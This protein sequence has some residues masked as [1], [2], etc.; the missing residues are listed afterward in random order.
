MYSNCQL[1]V[2]D[3]KP[4]EG[5]ILNPYLEINQGIVGY[6]PMW[7]GAGSQVFDLSGNGWTGTAVTSLVWTSGKFGSA[8]DFS[9][10]NRFKI[11][12]DF[13]T[14]EWSIVIWAKPSNLTASQY[15][16]D[17][18]Q[19]RTVILGI[20]NNYW[21]IFD[22]PTGNKHDTEIPAT[23]NEW[24]QICYTTDNVNTQGYKNGR[25]I[26][27]VV[28][29]SSIPSNNYYYIGAADTGVVP[30][31]GLMDHVLMYSRVLTVSEIAQLYRE[32]FCG[33]R[34]TNIVQ[35]ASY[36]ETA[37]GNPMLLQGQLLN[38]PLLQ[39]RLIA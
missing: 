10:N 19:K 3:M 4:P 29:A 12:D 14:N 30:F 7:S 2:P 39:G 31:L 16:T 1:Y 35:L 8:L 32:P 11:E 28:G 37:V 26:I 9:S 27:D 22:Y 23:A 24:Q 6:W 20:Q 21:N 18:N 25:L 15:L 5:S 38:S 34:W 17:G 33:F 36:Y 13:S